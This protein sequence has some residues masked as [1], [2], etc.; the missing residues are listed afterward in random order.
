LLGHENVATT[1]R[2]LDLELNLETT[3]SDFIPLSA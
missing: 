1:Q 3:A 2:Y